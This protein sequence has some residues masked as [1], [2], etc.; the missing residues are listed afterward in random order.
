LGK[1]AIL[2]VPEI[3]EAANSGPLPEELRDQPNRIVFYS[4][5]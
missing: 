3:A 2:S 1:N 5:Q 4:R